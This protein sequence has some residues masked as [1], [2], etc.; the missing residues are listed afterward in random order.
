MPGIVDEVAR[1]I[2]AERDDAE[3]VRAEARKNST[4][5]D[6]KSF[7]SRVFG[8]AFDW[9]NLTQAPEGLRPKTDRVK[10]QVDLPTHLILGEPPIIDLEPLP[11]QDFEHQ[12]GMRVRDVQALAEKSRVFIN[13]YAQTPTVWEGADHLLGLVKQSFSVG[14]RVEAYFRTIN[15]MFE[16]TKNRKSA[17]FQDIVA[18]F[19]RKE[20][21]RFD[22]LLK[23]VRG[24]EERIAKNMG[25]WWA[26]LDSI[27]HSIC[28]PLEVNPDDLDIPTTF[29]KL[30]L[31]KYVF[32]SRATAAAGGQYYLGPQEL[33]EFRR[34]PQEGDYTVARQLRFRD[35]SK[36]Q[37]GA[38][39]TGELLSFRRA[40]L[41]SHQLA[42]DQFKSLERYLTSP[43]HDEYKKKVNVAL[44]AINL[45]VQNGKVPDTEFSSLKKYYDEQV[46]IIVDSKL[47]KRVTHGLSITGHIVGG[48]VAHSLGFAVPEWE[49]A[50]AGGVAGGLVGAWIGHELEP[51]F[52]SEVVLKTLYKTP[53]K[54]YEVHR[55]CQIA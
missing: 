9:S 32:A 13:V 21:D 44:E 35:G 31:K 14:Q 53:I 11:E 46:R 47:G 45:A 17:E 30:R 28:Q 40:N 43:E 29:E 19:K 36:D 54:L 12:Y 38:F 1:R 8:K 5:V 18:R 49:A 2:R 41:V 6:L 10:R 37:I 20:P 24:G 4:H 51:L 22:Q 42:D 52:S 3:A 23:V 55:I 7:F 27:S 34:Y 33:N 25:T 48:T 26:Y 15:P 16:D 39:L 50:A